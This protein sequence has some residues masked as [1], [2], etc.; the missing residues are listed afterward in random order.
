VWLALIAGLGPTPAASGGSYVLPHSAM[1]N[2]Y[3]P[4]PP[5]SVTFTQ[6]LQYG[7]LP[8]QQLDL[9]QP[10]GGSPPL[11]ALVL[12]HGGGVAGGDKS[13]QADRC[14]YFAQFGVLVANINNRL[15]VKGDS[16]TLWPA[17]IEDSQLAVRWLR[18]NATALGIDPTRVCSIG[19]SSGSMM[20][21]MVGYLNAIFPGDM[22]DQ[23]TDQSPQVGCVIENF[24][25]VDFLQIPP[26]TVTQ[27]ENHLF[28]SSMPIPA[29]CPATPT[30]FACTMSPLYYVTAGAAQTLTV[31]GSQ[32][33]LV[34]PQN[35]VELNNALTSLGIANQAITYNGSHIFQGLTS[36]QEDLIFLQEAQYL[37]AIL[38]P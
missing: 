7:P 37:Q 6:N 33:T 3:P 2:V 12:F 28:G 36:D 15:T 13:T 11:P 35:A 14:V 29:S 23:I 38:A 25:P 4:V 9:C 8:I 24:G 19:F 27:T 18:S 34:P 30:N 31:Q 26:T 21:M 10:N 16:T 17:Y 5:G 32:D 1:S 22:A 20:A